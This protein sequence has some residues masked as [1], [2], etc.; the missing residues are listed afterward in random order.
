MRAT[1]LAAT[2]VAATF[3]AVVWAQT[4]PTAVKLPLDNL[5]IEH[6]DIIVPDTATSARFYARIAEPSVMEKP[7]SDQPVLIVAEMDL[8]AWIRRGVHSSHS[9]THRVDDRPGIRGG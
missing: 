8:H 7:T 5:G 2:C 1:L 4:A 6:L 9:P 3:G